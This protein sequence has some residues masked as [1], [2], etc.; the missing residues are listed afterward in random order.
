MSGYLKMTIWP[1]NRHKDS[2]TGVGRTEMEDEPDG[3]A[4]G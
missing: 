3:S 2:A 1:G 4:P